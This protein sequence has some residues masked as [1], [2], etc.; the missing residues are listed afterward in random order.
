MSDAFDTRVHIFN[1]KA[2]CAHIPRN[3]GAN[4]HI[5]SSFTCEFPGGSQQSNLI[6]DIFGL[7]A[8]ERLMIP[9]LCVCVF[10]CAWDGAI[11]CGVCV[12][13]RE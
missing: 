9:R 5:I 4:S 1:N 6:H 7:C 11:G 3:I 2:K 12:R 10:V 13:V 8:G